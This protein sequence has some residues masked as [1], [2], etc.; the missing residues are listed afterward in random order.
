MQ[1]M[2]FEL[3]TVIQCEDEIFNMT[4]NVEQ[5]SKSL[6]GLPAKCIIIIIVITVSSII[7]YDS[8]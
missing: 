2:N 4:R 5:A 7:F 1:M 6:P 3:G 8:K